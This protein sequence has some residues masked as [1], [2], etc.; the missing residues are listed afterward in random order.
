[1]ILV[2]SIAMTTLAISLT[3]PSSCETTMNVFSYAFRNLVSH[4]MWATSRKLVGS[5]KINTSL[6]FNRSLAKIIFSRIP[7]DKRSIL[8]SKTSISIPNPPITLLKE[9]LIL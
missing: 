7:E 2:F 6:S 3:K 9:D 4:S 1:M 8:C 5:S